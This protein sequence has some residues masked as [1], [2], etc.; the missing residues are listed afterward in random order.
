[1]LYVVNPSIETNWNVHKTQKESIYEERLSN[2]LELHECTMVCVDL[3]HESK[4]R[5]LLD[6]RRLI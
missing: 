5:T 4:P 6:W 3:L 1:M 2:D